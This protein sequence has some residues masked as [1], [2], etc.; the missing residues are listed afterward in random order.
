VIAKYRGL[1]L[2]AKDWTLIILIL[3]A[4]SAISWVIAGFLHSGKSPSG[5]EHSISTHADG[6]VWECH[7]VIVYDESPLGELIGSYHFENQCSVRTE[8]PCINTAGEAKQ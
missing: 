7:D 2:D 4:V 1:N 3:A 5:I 8:Y 6:C